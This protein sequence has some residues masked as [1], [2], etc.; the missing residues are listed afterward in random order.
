MGGGGVSCGPM[1]LGRWTAEGGCPHMGHLLPHIC[2]IRWIG[3]VAELE[4]PGKVSVKG[5]G[6]GNGI[7]QECPI[8]TG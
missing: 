8:H 5:K 6:N 4:V 1:N 2:H 7:G 3:V